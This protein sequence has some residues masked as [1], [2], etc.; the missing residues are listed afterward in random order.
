M[1]ADH[2]AILEGVDRF[3]AQLHPREMARRDAEHVPPYDYLEKLGDIGLIRA[4][5]REPLGG[6]GLPWSVF[7]RIQERLGYHAQ[8]IASILNRVVSFGVMPLVL[9]GSSAQQDA[10]IPGLLDGRT[11]IALALTEPGA[12]SD[13]RAVT[14]R[15]VRD[16][17]GWRVLGRKTWISDAGRADY[18]LTLCRSSE[19]GG[20]G[21]VALLVP[22]QAPGISMTVIPKVGNNCMPSW[23]IGYDDVVVPDALRLGPVGRGFRTVTGTLRFSRACLSATIVG[24][25]QAALDLAIAHARGRVQF[26]K[27]LTAFQVLRHRLVDMRIEVQ[28]ARLMV[29]ELAR[30]VDEDEPS[31]EMA[32]MT[33]IVATEMFQY[34]TDHGMQILA[35]AGYASDSAM[36]RYWRDSRLYSFGEGANE[37]QREIVARQMGLME[38]R[39]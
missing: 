28:K 22:R 24:S 23:D 34:V 21:L 37:I 38:K 5:V 32:A 16:G 12:G 14:T 11:L 6:L 26:G 35:S 31:D 9:F 39:A 33:K 18:L 25:A 27:P 15:A 36:Q 29:R 13:A 7:C 2:A 19:P 4:P 20:D 17:D 3:C 30:M 10:L 8:P 1:N